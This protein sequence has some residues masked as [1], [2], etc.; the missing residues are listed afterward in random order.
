MLCVNFDSNKGKLKFFHLLFWPLEGK[1]PLFAVTVFVG[2][3]VQLLV[4]PY[5]RTIGLARRRIGRGG[6]I[7]T[8]R[9]FHP[10]QNVFESLPLTHTDPELSQPAN[11]TVSYAF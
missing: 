10:A 9:A 11:S 1:I 4:K 8:D 5:S 2:S 7:I 6:R 3:K